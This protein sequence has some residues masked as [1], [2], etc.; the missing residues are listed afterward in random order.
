MKKKTKNKY[1]VEYL[2][3]K[4]IAWFKRK[5]PT[6]NKKNLKVLHTAKFK[7]ETRALKFLDII[8]Y[9]FVLTSVS[10]MAVVF[11]KGEVGLIALIK[12]FGFAMAEIFFCRATGRAIA[13]KRKAG[14][15]WFCLTVI[16]LL[17]VGFNLIYDW[18]LLQYGAPFDKGLINTDFVVLFLAIGGSG[19][20]GLII[21]GLSVM[22]NHQ[23]II[24]EQTLTV[25]TSYTKDFKSKSSAAERQ[26]KY[27]AKKKL[28]LKRVGLA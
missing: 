6:F 14:F 8:I 20:T 18:Y 19:M 28:E 15:L 24:V 27:R 9:A 10:Q 11:G 23:E 4:I 1:T 13:A 12:A 21:L 5:P 22:R 3:N 17:S 16:L 7:T 26:A 2:L 25:L